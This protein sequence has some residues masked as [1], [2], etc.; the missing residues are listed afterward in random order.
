M[1]EQGAALRAST[2]VPDANALADASEN[3]PELFALVLLAVALA[4]GAFLRFEHL[5]R[6]DLSADEGATWAAASQPTA[7]EVILKEHQFDPGKLP[8]YDLLLHGW[9]RGFGEDVV[10]MR[11]MSAALGTL[12]IALVFAA[13]RESC[14]SLGADTDGID[15]NLAGAFAALIYAVS[16]MTVASDRTLRMY[17][18]EVGA[19]LAQ[20][21]FL[22]R[23]ARHHGW[24]N[25]AGTAVF[26]AL[27]I[28]ANFTASFLLLGEA[29]WLGCLLVGRLRGPQKNGLLIFQ[30]ALSVIAGVAI[31]SP[32]L[33][34]AFAS[35]RM[36]VAV[37]ALDWIKMQPPWWPY[38][39]LSAAAR[40]RFLFWSFLG[41]AAFAVWR[42]WRSSPALVGFFAAWTLGPFLGVMAVTYLVRP[43]E[44]PRYAL[45]G[46]IGMYAFAGFG[47][48]S[49]RTHSRRVN[50]SI[51][52]GITGALIWLSFVPTHHKLR[53]PYE[54]DWR[55]AAQVA[56]DIAAPDETIAVF[57]RFCANV[58]RYYVPPARRSSVLGQDVCGS[59]RV[60]VLTGHDIISEDQMSAM[61][62]C[63]PRVVKRLMLV[64]VR[65][66]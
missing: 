37:G 56:V 2:I 8:V 38:I 4:L 21:I 39:V 5:R 16:F 52:L 14:R 26:T 1:S 40:G 13:V 51:R 18:L 49:L 7:N 27:M 61:E 33:P 11:A 65:T 44:F 17:P 55:G 59:P 3:R 32:W 54:A 62:R 66:R 50:M 47:A 22:V 6:P 60:L 25:Y 12:A 64:E 45:I 29:I 46:C 31:L 19:E 15:G 58:V 24:L 28:A 41:F 63:Y 10:A 9:M 48:A 43:L 35:S 30:P 42:Y 23:A 53:H 34:A 36:A 20:I 57:P